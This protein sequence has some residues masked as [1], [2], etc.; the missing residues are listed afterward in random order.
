MT[1]VN[2]LTARERC[3][4]E[5]WPDGGGGYG[6]DNEGD[7]FR[8]EHG[9]IRRCFRET[10]WGYWYDRRRSWARLGPWWDPIRYRRAVAALAAAEDAP[11][12]A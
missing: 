4:R 9:V 8:C 7:V 5:C 2:D 1:T 11:T 10:G 12:N 3:D 6:W